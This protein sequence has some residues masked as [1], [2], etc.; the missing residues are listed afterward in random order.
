MFNIV[1]PSCW[2]ITTILLALAVGCSSPQQSKNSSL[3]STPALTPAS[4]VSSIPASD[5]IK[6]A[7]QLFNNWVA[8]EWNFDQAVFDLYAEDA[9]IQNTRQYPDGK[10]RVL[11]F[12]SQEWKTLGLKAMPLA[13]SVGDRNK[14]SQV[15]YT[16]E[17]DRVRISTQRY[18]LRKQYSSPR[19]LLVGPTQTGEWR[20]FEDISFSQP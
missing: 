9:L 16:V 20:I 18:S 19:S 8:L 7:E 5:L 12:S 15:T 4:K 3:F 17:G 1:K 6:K 2:Y 10:T 11:R 14:Y 13:R